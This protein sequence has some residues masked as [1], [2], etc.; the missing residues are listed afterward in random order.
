MRNCHVA[1]IVIALLF[2]GLLPGRA[3]GEEEN[4]YIR[5]QLPARRLSSPPTIDGDISDPVWTEAAVGDTFVDQ[6]TNRP[7][8]DQTRMWVGYDSDAIYVAAYC[9]DARPDALVMLETKRDAQMW[10]DDGFT[11]NLDPYHTHNWDDFFAFTVNPRGTQSSRMGGGRS[12]KTEW[13]GDWQAAARVVADGWT[14]EMAVPW[15]ILNFPSKKEPATLGFNAERRHARLDYRSWFSNIGMEWRN[16]YGAD[17]VGVELPAGSFRPEFLALPFVAAGAAESDQA[18]RSTARA[19]VDIRYRPTPALTGVLTVNPDF[20]NVQGEVEGIDFSRGERW[21]R[22]SR[23]FFQEGDDMFEMYSGVGSYFYSRRIQHID[24]GGKLYGKLAKRTNVGMLGTLDLDGELTDPRGLRRQDYVFSLTQGAGEWGS[25]STS[26][27]W[28]RDTF[29]Q[30]AVMGYRA[31]VRIRRRAHV[32]LKYGTS[33]WRGPT[34]AEAVDESSSAARQYQRGELGG[35]SVGWGKGGFGF[36][37]DVYFVSPGF[38]A[39]NGFVEFPGRRGISLGGGY[40]DEWRTSFIRE[41]GVEFGGHYEE[42][43]E[44]GG[45]LED[46]DGVIRRAFSTL[47]ARDAN[48]RFFRDGLGYWAFVDTRNNLFLHHNV[49]IGHFREEGSPTS[50]LD[51]SASFGMGGRNAQRT[52]NGGFRYSFGRADGAVRHFLSPRIFEKWGRFS[53]GLDG[54]FLRHKERRQQHTISANYDIST[55]I[56]VGGR[57]IFQRNEAENANHWNYYV[58][59]RRSGEAGLETFLIL[60]DPS[61]ERFVPRVEGKVLLPL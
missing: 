52:R 13:K 16:E 38:R 10:G 17:W 39:S 49:D 40:F 55:T 26:G 35:L 36:G 23:P 8:A 19:G 27:V 42:R 4:P 21:V 31:Q 2:A 20:R 18:W 22:E 41:G 57:L 56:T 47:G 3:L 44:Q 15:A 1:C 25:F 33:A 50:D 51:W 37:P 6:K 34:D 28:K 48:P 54:S 5:R 9:Y 43:Y 7:V 60:G 61:A 24:M 58:S 53:A 45:G 46:L 30:N 29:E 14:A 59:L 12:G 11:I 32:N